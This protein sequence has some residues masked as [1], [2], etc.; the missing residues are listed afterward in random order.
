MLV[1]SHGLAV[2]EYGLEVN[3]P[4]GHKSITLPDISESKITSI[5]DSISVFIPLPIVPNLGKPTISL[6]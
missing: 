3:A 4:T 6:K 5:Y 2:N 1:N